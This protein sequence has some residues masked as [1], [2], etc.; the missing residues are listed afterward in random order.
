MPKLNHLEELFI[1]GRLIDEA[2]K[3]AG[4]RAIWEAKQLGF[5][6]T[7]SENG[8]VVTIPP[9]EIV[10]EKPVANFPIPPK[11]SRK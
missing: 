6:I 7:V 9:E 2:L 3:Y 11:G 1:D 10:I 5:P 4:Q 8:K